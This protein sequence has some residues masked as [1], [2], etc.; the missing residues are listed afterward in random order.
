M[1]APLILATQDRDRLSKLVGMFGS[2]NPN[3]RAV[4]AMKATQLLGAFGATWADI[5]SSLPVATPR[6]FLTRPETRLAAAR[7]AASK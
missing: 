7:M 6:R 1:S 3:E 5:V 2:D 4:A